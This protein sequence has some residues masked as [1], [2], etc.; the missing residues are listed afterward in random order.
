[1]ISRCWGLSGLMVNS[2][3]VAAP[4]DG[5]CPTIKK[6]H[7]Y[8][9]PPGVSS[10]QIKIDKAPFIC[11]FAR[12][13]GFRQDVHTILPYRDRSPAGRNLREPRFIG[14]CRPVC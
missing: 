3:A 14:L 13:I 10:C 6:H 11:Y 5:E 2:M 8:Y 4:V 9:G 7:V 1:M 12:L